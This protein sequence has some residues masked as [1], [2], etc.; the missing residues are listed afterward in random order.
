MADTPRSRDPG[1]N[2]GCSSY[3][4]ED[5]YGSLNDLRLPQKDNRLFE[6]SFHLFGNPKYLQHDIV[7]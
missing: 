1:F 6:Y 4:L 3:A 2:E 5:K 7:H